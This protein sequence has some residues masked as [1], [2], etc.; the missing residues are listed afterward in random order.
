MSDEKQDLK[1]SI[2]DIG[3]KLKEYNVSQTLENVVKRVQLAEKLGYT[4]YWF[5][6]HHNTPNQV[7]TSPELM[8]MHAAAH[9]S[10]IQIGAGGIMMPNHSPLKVVE[11]FSLLTGFYPNRIDLGIG[12]AT[13]TD[14]ITSFALRR[15]REA[16]VNYQFDEQF[17]EMLSFFERS[18][19]EELPYHKITP[20][21]LENDTPLIPEMYMLGSSNGGVQF[22]I[23]EGLGFVFAG[24]ISPQ[25]AIPMLRKYHN[26]FKPSKY[27]DKPKGIFSTIVITAETDEEAAYLAG[28]V[29]LNFV[30]MHTGNLHLPFPTA[31]EA[32]QHDYSAHEEAI[33]ERNKNSFI[34]GSVENVAKRLRAIA[35]EAM[36]DEV[37]MM[38]FYPDKQS[39][40]KAYQLL[41]KEFNLKA[42]E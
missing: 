39:S 29:E 12:R 15:S 24:H 40:D 32:S 30:R 7:S 14:P 26:E 9:T 20:I 5:A 22:A 35:D 28:P 42:Q 18:F 31:E 4:R 10:H 37:M 19:P 38:E 2:L 13:G 23:E 25:L 3:T 34:I 27:N 41:A 36:V 11:N 21:S 33:R 8:I 1:L 6:E 17:N 16:V